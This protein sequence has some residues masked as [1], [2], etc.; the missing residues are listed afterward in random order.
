MPNTAEISTITPEDGTYPNIDDEVVTVPFPDPTVSKTGPALI[1]P[2][3]NFIWKL[4]YRNL[5][6]QAPQARAVIDTPPDSLGRD[7][8]A[9]VQYLSSSLACR[10][11]RLLFQ[12]TDQYAPPCHLS[13]A[14]TQVGARAQACRTSTT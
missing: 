7:G 11:H 2:G 4:T 5:T 13:V 14:R 6:G 12:C 1:V 3:E 10:R 9:D 8:I